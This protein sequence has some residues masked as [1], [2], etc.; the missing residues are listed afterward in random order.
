MEYVMAKVSFLGSDDVNFKG[1]T[2]MKVD[3]LESW[4]KNTENFAKEII[5]EDGHIKVYHSDNCA[6]YFDSAE[7]ILRSI[8]FSKITEDEFKTLSRL[9]GG[10]DKEVQYGNRIDLLDYEAPEPIESSKKKLKR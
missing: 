7:E 3:S 9:L 1:F 5:E 2:A 8:K 10:N 4:Q 6:T